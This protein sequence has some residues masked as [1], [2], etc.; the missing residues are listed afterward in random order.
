MFPTDAT[1]LLANVGTPLM[2]AGAF[3][4]FIGNAIIGIGEG[5]LIARL[6]HASYRR[7]IIAMI[8]ANYFSLFTATIALEWRGTPM[9]PIFA[10]VTIENAWTILAVLLFLCILF[11]AILEWPFCW[12]GLHGTSKR[13]GKSIV[14]TIVAQLASYAILV[15]WYLS[16]GTVS[17]LTRVSQAP[18]ATFAKNADATVYYIEVDT[19]DVCRMNGDGAHA[20]TVRKLEL[21][22]RNTRLYCLANS[23]GADA[24]LFARWGRDEDESVVVHDTLA[25]DPTRVCESPSA[26]ELNDGTWLHFGKSIDLRPPDDAHWEV[27]TGF[28]AA[29]GL[30]AENETTHERLW[31]ALET[32]VMNWPSRNATILPHDQIIYQLGDQIVLVDLEARKIGLLARGRGPFVVPSSTAQPAIGVDG[33][34]R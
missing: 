21:H 15:P 14:A 3:H 2:L 1:S 7:A 9:Q 12:L 16:V 20:E 23:N 30:T 33:V 18:P 13:L 26:T 29:E 34:H 24:Q 31:L 8:V 22:D 11:S 19:G 25:V 32:P 27:Q 5:T 17:V 28:W 4:L 6:F 10:D